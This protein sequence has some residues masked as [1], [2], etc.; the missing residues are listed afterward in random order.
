MV[1]LLK[2]L[3]NIYPG[4]FS[5]KMGLCQMPLLAKKKTGMG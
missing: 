2:K 4:S 5:G 1:P 3:K